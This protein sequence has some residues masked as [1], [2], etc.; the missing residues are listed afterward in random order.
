M[1]VSQ[2]LE[3]FIEEA[4]EHLQNLNVSLL[5]MEKDTSNKEL[6][7]EIFRVAHTLKGMAGTMGFKKMNVLT[8]DMENVLSEIRNGTIDVDAEM[9]DVMFNCL[10][11]LEGYVDSIVETS[12]EGEKEHKDII[13]RLNN[14]LNGNAEKEEEKK[15]N[16][17]SAPVT[18][19]PVTTKEDNGNKRKHMMLAL[20][21]FEKNTMLKAKSE[22]FKTFGVTV[23]ISENCVLKSARAFIIFRALEGLGEIVKSYPSVQDIEDEKF[24][25]GFSVFVLT[26]EDEAKFQKDLGSIAEVDEV[27]I[28]EIV[29]EGEVAS[30]EKEEEPVKEEVSKTKEDTKQPAAQN[31]GTQ[32]KAKP[33]AN[34]TVRVDIDRLDTLMNLVSEL[35]IVKNGLET[36]EV[37]NASMSEQIEYLERI[38]TNLNEAVMK[39]RMVPVERVFNR[40]PR[41]I[42]DLSRKLNKN[43]ELHMS[44]EE[45][46]LDRTVIDEIGDPLVHL[47][48]NSGDHGLETPDERVAAGKDKVGNVYLT[49]YQDGNNVVIEVGDDGRGI[50]VEKVKN[51]AL[52]NGAITK[53]QAEAMSDQDI[54][55]LLF[56]PS[57]STADQIS[58][59]SGRGV[60]LDVVKTKIEALGGD[61]EVKTELGKGST[62]IIRLPLT[63]AILQALMVNL[64]DEKY[65]IPLNTIQN[66]EDV[67][68][69]DIKLIQNQEVINLRGKVVPIIRLGELL[70]VEQEKDEAQKSMTV[71]VVNK[72]D[73]QAGLVVDGLIGQQEIVIKT[74]GSYLMNIKLIAGA[75]ILGDGEV[76]LILDV[77][78]LV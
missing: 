46:E 31:S 66:I 45:T 51:K 65:A 56:R 59:V 41:L 13:E 54:I 7:N 25:D 34:R 52:N 24:D 3:I 26:Q 19:S 4:K 40:F 17:A 77:N 32:K 73:K 49:A 38:A 6:V 70:G 22:G 50:D 48:R 9:L 55:D 10:D 72:G 74:L 47:I 18:S 42:R 1:D 21:E 63:L 39:V 16:E 15:S 8:H 35:I 76:A 20:N 62:F 28:D 5:E 67:Q 30:V 57:F 71:V 69:E 64:G 33:N 44:G 2:Y 58:D 27:L 61:I 11:A 78:S 60:G 53:D 12:G 29:I 43:M 14:I 75:T 37:Q 68:L 23:M 36:I